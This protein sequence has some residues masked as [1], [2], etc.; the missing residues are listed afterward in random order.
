MQAVAYESMPFELRAMLHQRVGEDIERTE[1]EH[2]ERQLDLL[3]HHYWNS[4]DEA[5][6]REYLW[7][8]GAAQAAYANTAAIDYFERPAPARW[9]RARPVSG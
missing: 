2:L 4:N 6:K 3:A 9:Q 7:R 5:K 8:A 1:A